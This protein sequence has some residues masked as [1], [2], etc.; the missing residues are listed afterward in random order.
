[1][2]NGTQELNDRFKG[3]DV[4]PNEEDEKRA[5]FRRACLVISGAEGVGV[6]PLIR[7]NHITGRSTLYNV[8]FVAQLLNRRPRIHRESLH[9]DASIAMQVRSF[10]MRCDRRRWCTRRWMMAVG[11]PFLHT[12][13]SYSA[14]VT[15]GRWQQ[16][17][18]QRA[19]VL[20]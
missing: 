10:L 1:M 2:L 3:D 20:L 5:P 6:A 11:S 7:A 9:L 15:F 18:W 19:A 4:D 12:I 14:G 8:A 13:Y 17:R 16:Q